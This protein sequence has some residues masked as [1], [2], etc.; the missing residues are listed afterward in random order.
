MVTYTYT[1]TN[2][3]NISLTGVTVTDDRGASVEATRS[4]VVLSS[5]LSNGVEWT[6]LSS[7][8]GDLEAPGTQPD[9][10]VALV[11][12]LSGDGVNDFV[13]GARF[14]SQGPTVVWYERTSTGWIKHVIEPD[15]LNVEA[16][17]VLH[18]IDGDGVRD[19]R[20][21][22]FTV[23]WSD[24]TTIEGLATNGELHPMQQAFWDKHGLQCGYCTPGMIMSA[25]KLVE[26]NPNPSE[27]EIRHGLDGNLCRCTGYKKV[28]EAVMSV[29]AP[30]G[31]EV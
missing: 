8:A 30:S 21:G 18:D 16:G 1:V 27:A 20:L 26:N 4:V 31:K 10:T 12:D 7:A 13:I 22:D 14:G 29:T 5:D 2:T 25:V 15:L 23:P 17:G 9:Q 3:G 19:N 6:H 28:V 24:I 11:G